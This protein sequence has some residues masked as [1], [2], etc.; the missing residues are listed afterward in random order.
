[1]R[2]LRPGRQLAPGRGDRRP[3]AGRA[4]RRGGGGGPARRPHGRGARRRAGRAPDGRPGAPGGMTAWRLLPWFVL[5]QAGFPVEWLDE[6]SSPAATAA[7]DAL[8]DSHE[9]L[10]GARRTA[11]GTL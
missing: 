6:L 9:V 3:A 4:R 5:R 1:H 2:L 8:L 10:L 7:A 11:L